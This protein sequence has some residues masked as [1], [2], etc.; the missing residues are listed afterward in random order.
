MRLKRDDGIAKITAGHSLEPAKILAERLTALRR[1]CAQPNL[2]ILVGV[3]TIVFR[4]SHS[5]CP[6]LYQIC[7]SFV[8]RKTNG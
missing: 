1:D 5:I 8:N 6:E 3:S 7:T 4:G 2:F